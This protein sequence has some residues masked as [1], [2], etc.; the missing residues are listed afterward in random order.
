[1]P[2]AKSSTSCSTDRAVPPRIGRTFR[3]VAQLRGDN[4]PSLPA[5]EDEPDEAVAVIVLAV[6]EEVAAK[7]KVFA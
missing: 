7:D 3:E 5:A 6:D 2:L 4:L 1:M